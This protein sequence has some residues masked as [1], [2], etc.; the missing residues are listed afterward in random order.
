MRLSIVDNP[1]PNKKEDWID[2]KQKLKAGPPYSNAVSKGLD[3]D[4][5]ELID[6]TETE[7]DKKANVDAI[8]EGVE[9]TKKIMDGI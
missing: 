5:F 3:A 2:P 7:A 8:N 9:A 4:L 6:D 1:D